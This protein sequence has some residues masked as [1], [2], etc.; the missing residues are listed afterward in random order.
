LALALLFFVLVVMTSLF[1]AGTPA[2]ELS[3]PQGRLGEIRGTQ[4]RRQCQ[5][6]LELELDWWDVTKC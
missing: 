5:R 3:G 2:V 6:V 1:C 4:R